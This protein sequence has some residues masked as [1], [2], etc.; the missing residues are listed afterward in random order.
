MP[1]LFPKEPGPLT[2]SALK[3]GTTS[4][5]PGRGLDMIALERNNAAGRPTGLSGRPAVDCPASAGLFL[6]QP[7][8]DCAGA[9]HGPA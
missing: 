8:Q 7:R 3:A 6:E 9:E 1:S 2:P 4:P 5:R